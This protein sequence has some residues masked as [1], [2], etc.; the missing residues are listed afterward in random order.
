MLIHKICKQYSHLLEI[1]ITYTGAQF[2]AI[3]QETAKRSVKT[4]QKSPLYFQR[5]ERGIKLDS[6]YFN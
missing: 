2:G 6:V 3:V 5:T 1:G 4:L